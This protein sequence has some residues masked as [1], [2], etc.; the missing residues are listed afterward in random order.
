M[1]WFPLGRSTD[2]LPRALREIYS[3]PLGLSTLLGW[4]YF[5]SAH[6]ASGKAAHLIA[7]MLPIGM[8][9]LFLS[10]LALAMLSWRNRDKEGGGK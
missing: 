5:K 1:A 7:V 2:R 4:H 10:N 6:T 9:C 3:P 8:G